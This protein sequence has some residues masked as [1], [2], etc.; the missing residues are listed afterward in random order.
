MRDEPAFPKIKSDNGEYANNSVM[1]VWSEGGLTKRELFAAMALQGM[2][3][4]SNLTDTFENFA[5]NSV[6]SAD[7]LIAELQ[8]T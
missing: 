6:K 8:K 2:L 3:S 7:A 5:R 4:D 1:S